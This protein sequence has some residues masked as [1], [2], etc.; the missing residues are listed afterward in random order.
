MTDGIQRS[1]SRLGET[2]QDL[3]TG[4]RVHSYADLG[5]NAVR[6]ISAHSMLSR[7][8]AEMQVSKHVETTLG[9]YDTHLTNM[10]NQLTEMRTQML[11][12]L[13]NEDGTGLQEAFEGAFERFRDSLNADEGGVYLFGGSSSEVKPFMPKDFQA[14]QWNPTVNAFRSDG[15]QAKATIG[16]NHT[17]TFGI[18]AREAGEQIYDAF[19]TLSQ[20]AP[21]KDGEMTWGN[22]TAIRTALEQLDDGLG[23][24]R[25]VNGENGRKM[26]KLDAITEAAEK[27]SLVFERII[28]ES[29]D[30]DLGKVATDLAKHQA[31]LQASYSVFAR[32]SSLSLTN[33]L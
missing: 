30:A 24:L 29:E 11:T 32:L 20:A 31:S 18:G 15:N 14:A 27:R 6:S 25:N 22:K 13:G 10:D 12:A 4:R 3:A 28:S 2:Q 9:L 21:F 19:R 1:Q 26:A 17:M 33:Y 5:S 8:K 7:H 23:K 16:E